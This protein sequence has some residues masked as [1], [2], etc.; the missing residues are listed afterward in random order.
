M[1]DKVCYIGSVPVDVFDA[2]IERMKLAYAALA[3]EKQILETELET[4]RQIMNQPW[5][6]SHD[7][8]RDEA[9]K[10]IAMISL[11]L[12]MNSDPVTE[13]TPSR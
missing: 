7:R 9:H 8:G 11:A 5:N 6:D 10:R 4:V 1:T 2:G 12:N 3:E 13:D